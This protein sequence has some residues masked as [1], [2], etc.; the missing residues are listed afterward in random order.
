MMAIV[1]AM[2]SGAVRCGVGWDGWLGLLVWLDGMDDMSTT[3]ISLS[4]FLL[5]Y[6]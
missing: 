6:K 2:S 4:P 1:K 3:M 5:I